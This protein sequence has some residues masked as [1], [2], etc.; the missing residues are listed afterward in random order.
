MFGR[1][2]EIGGAAGNRRGNIGAFALLDVDAD[3]GILPQKRGKRFRQML[4]QSRGGGEQL[5]AG[6]HAAGI[7]GETAAQRIDIVH[8]DPGMMEQAFA[9]R[10][11][12]DAAAAAFQQHCAEC[13][14]QALDPRA[15]G[16]QREMGAERAA[17]DAALVGHGNKQLEVDQIEPNGVCSVCLRRSRRLAQRVADCAMRFDRSILGD[18]GTFSVFHRRGSAARRLR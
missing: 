5:H 11:Q 8:D 12:P 4:G 17:R 16:C 1:K 14:F 10:G 7:G 9:R 3:V 6:P 13:C 2:A 15:G 18:V